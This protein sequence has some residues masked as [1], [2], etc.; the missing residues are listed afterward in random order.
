MLL[1]SGEDCDY[2]QYVG[3]YYREVINKIR[4]TFIHDWDSAHWII[5]FD[6]NGMLVCC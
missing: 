2:L 4:P 6:E 5:G 3:S 1:I